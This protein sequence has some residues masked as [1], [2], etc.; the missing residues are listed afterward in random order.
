MATTE[1][2]TR[3]ESEQEHRTN[4]SGNPLNR[5][6]LNLPNLITGSRLV[7]AIVLFTLIYIQGFWITSAV[8]FVFAAWTDALDGWIA[9]KYGMVTVLGRILDPFVDKIIIGGAF[10]FLSEKSVELDSGEILHSGVNAWMAIIIIGREMFIT[11]LRG[12]LE[13]QGKDFSASLSGKIK[14]VLQCVAVPVALLSLDPHPLF[15]S[16]GYILFRDITLW[17][18]VAVTV[19]SGVIYVFRAVEMLRSE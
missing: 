15:Q 9:R 8:V 18:A 10:I 1:N 13:Q 4:S 19:L 11:S 12:F 14:M 16:D 5:D 2:S 3:P 17:S 6:A 7:L